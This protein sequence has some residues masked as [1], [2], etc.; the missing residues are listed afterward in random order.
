M[1]TSCSNLIINKYKREKKR[2]TMLAS[3]MN[4]AI[5]ALSFDKFNLAREGI[6]WLFKL[7]GFVTVVDIDDEVDSSFLFILLLLVTLFV[8]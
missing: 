7:Y 5:M 6:D 8:C 1:K 4:L 2:L 3:W